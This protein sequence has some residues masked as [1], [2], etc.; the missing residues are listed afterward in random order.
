MTQTHSDGKLVL[1]SQ[2]TDKVQLQLVAEFTPTAAF[3]LWQS[4][5]WFYATSSEPV[6]VWWLTAAT[7]MYSNL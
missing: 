1:Q 4:F 3:H 5:S 2:P 6:S 7:R